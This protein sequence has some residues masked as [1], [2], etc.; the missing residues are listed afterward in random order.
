M[1]QRTDVGSGW[2][3][4]QMLA[5]VGALAVGAAARDLFDPR[6]L[7]ERA[8]L[9]MGVAQRP[10]HDV[11]QAAED[12]TPLAGGLVGAKAVVGLHLGPAPGAGLIHRG[13]LRFASATRCH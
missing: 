8:R 2:S 6:G 11:L 12:R 4:R 5:G 7:G 10:G 13:L 1:G 3:R 9:P